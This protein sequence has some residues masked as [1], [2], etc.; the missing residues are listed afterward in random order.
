[1][2]IHEERDGASSK[3]KYRRNSMIRKEAWG[4]VGEW[5]IDRVYVRAVLWHVKALLHSLEKNGNNSAAPSI[6][7]RRGRARYKFRDRK[8]R[9]AFPLFYLLSSF[10]FSWYQAARR[11]FPPRF[12]FTLR[13]SVSLSL[14]DF[15]RTF[16]T[17]A[18]PAASTLS[19]I[20]P[21]PRRVLP[22][23]ILTTPIKI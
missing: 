20:F 3:E 17:P 13:E 2:G 18:S 12:S 4:K 5:R 7:P 19:V 22:I 9:M 23:C 1:M 8:N 10:I 16:F 11:L 21:V 14:F 15:A 6:S